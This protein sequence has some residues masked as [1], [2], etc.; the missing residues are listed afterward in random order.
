LPPELLELAQ[1]ELPPEELELE[2]L[3]P[4]EEE[5]V[6]AFASLVLDIIAVTRKMA[7][8]Q[9]PIPNKISVFFI[10]RSLI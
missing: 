5:Q 7:I 2:L 6:A 1:L 10:R 8:V 4:D 9:I 3:D